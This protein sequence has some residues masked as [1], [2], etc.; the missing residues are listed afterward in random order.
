MPPWHL[1][2]PNACNVLLWSKRHW[3]TEEQ[4]EVHTACVCFSFG[5]LK[6]SIGYLNYLR[7]SFS[8][9]EVIFCRDWNH[10]KFYFFFLLSAFFTGQHSPVH[11]FRMRSSGMALEFSRR[12]KLNRD[13]I[14][15]AQILYS[16]LCLL[17]LHI[18]RMSCSML[19]KH[20]QMCKYF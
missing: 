17:L 11:P 20:L 4:L 2:F 16:W 18:L 6:C 10:F 13:Q 14:W 3:R 1:L 15:T 7:N 12:W 5:Y 19:K 9:E 8:D